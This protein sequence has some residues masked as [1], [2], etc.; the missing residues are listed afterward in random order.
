MWH[1]CVDVDNALT[2]LLDRLC[3]WEREA[4]RGSTLIL[5]PHNSDE[6][7]VLAMDGKP[8]D[9]TFSVTP[10]RLVEIAMHERSVSEDKKKQ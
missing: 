3:M 8:L 10:N 2:E 5:I 7:I 9:S 4:G 1:K 6:K